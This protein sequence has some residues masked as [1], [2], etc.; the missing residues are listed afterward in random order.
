MNFTERQAKALK[1]E[2]KDR[3]V[4]AGDGLY[5]NVRHKSKTW[6][7][8]RRIRGKYRVRTLGKHPRMPVKE[9]RILAL[10]D[11]I[12]G[13]PS[14]MTGE[15]LAERYYTEVV[16]VEHK[17]PELFRGYLD[18]AVIPGIGSRRLVEVTPADLAEVIGDY[19]ARGARSADQ[20]LSALRALFTFAIEI[21]IR[22]DNPAAALTRRVAGYRPKGRD[23]VLSDNE[24]R[25]L[26]AE[27]SQNARVLRFLVLTGLRISDAQN[28]HR[29]GNRWID[30]AEQSKNGRA[31]WVHLTP[32]ALDQ[33]PLPRSTPTNI[34][35]WTR[36]WCARSSIA[37][38]FTPHDCRRTAATRMADNGVEP[39][40][41]ERALNHTLQGVMGIYNRAEYQAERMEAAKS[42]ESAILDALRPTPANVVGLRQ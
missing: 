5:Q 18:R 21:G 6:L 32:S 1:W 36:R 29:H 25:A 3:L 38:H 7:L 15:V 40:V 27:E 42:L 19:R 23:R 33:L 2:G 12:E 10:Q 24:V 37:P 8:R 31:H 9:A 35:A 26:W 14:E 16:E 22:T 28:G 41:V 39:F 13:E 11:A 20:L 34:Q 17:R 4:S 30:S